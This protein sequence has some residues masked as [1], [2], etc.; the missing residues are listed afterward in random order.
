VLHRILRSRVGAFLSPAALPGN[1]VRR[2]PCPLPGRIRPGVEPLEA[3]LVPSTSP[4]IT[5]T[6]ANDE[7]GAQIQT[8]T[9]FGNPNRITLGILDTGASPV[10]VASADQASFADAFGNPD[11]IPIKIPGG[12]SGD[13]IGGGVTGDVSQPINILTDGLH[14][15]S[16]NLDFNTFNFTV[17]ANFNAT[18][19]KSTG[20]QTFVGTDTGSPDLPTISGT[21][22]LA[23][24]FNSRTGG[25]LAAKVDLINGVDFYGLGLLEPDI[26]F[27]AANS[28][29]TPGPTEQLA[30]IPLTTIGTSNLGSPGSDISSFYNFVANTVQLKLGSHS[31]NAT[32]SFLLDTGSQLTIIS[33]AEAKA[34]GITAATPVFDTIDVQG[35]GGIQTVNGYVLDSLTVG[36]T[37]G[38]MTVKN[39]P[40]FV[41]DIGSG[42]DG[43]LGMNLWNNADQL[44]ISP[45]S[46]G[47]TLS[48]TFSLTFDPNYTSGGGGGGGLFQFFAGHSGQPHT[49][50]EL[51]GSVASVVQIPATTPPNAVVM[52]PTVQPSAVVAAVT[53][54]TG[55][56]GALPLTAVQA[57]LNNS[58]SPG[59][60]V[61]AVPTNAIP[62]GVVPGSGV[63]PRVTPTPLTITAGSGSSAEQNLGTFSEE[64]PA[65]RAEPAPSAE[66]ALAAP[67]WRLPSLAGEGF[68]GGA[69]DVCFAE[70]G[71]ASLAAE[72]PAWPPSAFDSV[73]VTRL[74]AALAV[75]VGAY[76][77]AEPRMRAR[78]LAPALPA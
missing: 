71:G 2:R 77:L 19:A 7:F 27:V 15:A 56:A 76:R 49:L 75:V 50:N 35:V 46:N 78:T 21:P 38:R 41:L 3:R 18:S 70:D 30:T 29:L 59:V 47:K 40:V 11:P 68:A 64:A 24:A 25:K 54:T 17:T 69:V 42:I 60:N 26:H 62:P 1:A 43:I 28:K 22:I 73:D 53:A 33:S 23:G 32:Q 31:T 57:L 63:A 6:P 44:L 8:V 48:P 37:T 5:L 20:I 4:T 55:T 45:Y 13:G 16:L 39:V 74:V 12:A 67:A 36:L 51:L 10:T 9:Q 58:S 65:E 52:S 66:A 34:L 14:A 72:S 61:Q